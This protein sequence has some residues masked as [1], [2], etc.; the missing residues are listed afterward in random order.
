[1]NILDELTNYLAEKL[2]LEAGENLFYNSLPDE[3][4]EATL[5]QLIP[6]EDTMRG[7]AV[8]SQIDGAYNI[9]CVTT[10]SL[11]N[12]TAYIMGSN[13]Y[14]WLYTDKE[15]KSEADGLV[16]VSDTLT[17]ATNMLGVPV[18][19]KTDENGRKYFTFKVRVFSHR[20]I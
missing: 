9:V 3:P 19:T 11:S 10:R 12:A 8:P 15:D 7:Y 16:K 14:R 18:W 13:V 20:I 17:V 4:N 1:M 5:L 2:G 6:I